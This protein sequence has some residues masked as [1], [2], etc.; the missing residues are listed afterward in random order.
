MISSR[1]VLAIIQARYSSRRLPGKVLI[2][3]E[4]RS[5]LEHVYRRVEQANLVD[6]LVIATSTDPSD[7]RILDHCKKNKLNCFRGPLDDVLARFSECLKEYE[8]THVL[9][10]TADCPLI[11][12]DIIDAVILGA[13]SGDYDYYGIGE[14]FPDGVDCTLIKKETLLAANQ[15]AKLKSER[16]HVGPF[17][18]KNEEDIF[19]IGH[20][21][22]FSGLNHL[23]LCLDEERDL[24][25][26]K[27]IFQKLYRNQNYFGLLE[28]LMFL[29]NNPALSNINKGIMR[30]EGYH[31]SLL[32]DN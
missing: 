9:R 15:Q 3:I 23:R 5:V 18:E 28:V 27:S 29:N 20:L 8:C 1:K 7:D 25:L 14:D 10:I 26:I 11:D 32:Q 21:K 13:I 4:G 30:N 19:V 12:R 22:L 31:K 24:K 2:D 6:D 17:I 16:E